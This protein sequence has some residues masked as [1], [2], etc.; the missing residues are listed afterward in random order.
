M[1]V[2]GKQYSVLKE[3]LT[4]SDHLI[5]ELVL[6]NQEMKSEINR[7]HIMVQKL[8][9]ENE[10]LRAVVIPKENVP[11]LSTSSPPPG[12]PPRSPT[13]PLPSSRPKSMYEHRSSV[14]FRAPPALPTTSYVSRDDSGIGVTYCEHSSAVNSKDGFAAPLKTCSADAISSSSEYPSPTLPNKEEVFRKTEQITKRI[15]ELLVF[16]QEGKFDL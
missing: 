3:Q 10:Q 7:L 8:I 14:P 13:K 6:S 12:P 4:R 11:I 1:S 15:Q 2:V 9:D 5:Q 16:T